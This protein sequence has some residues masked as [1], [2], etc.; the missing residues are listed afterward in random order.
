MGKL[1]ERDSTGRTVNLTGVR[2]SFGDSL[3]TAS[4]PKKNKD[5]SARPTHGVNLIIEKD[6][7]HFQSNYDAIITALSNAAVE[8]K[9]P[10]EWWRSLFEDDPKQLCLRKGSRFKTAE[11]EVYKGYDG[12]LVLVL[13]GPRGG[14]KRPEIRDRYKKIIFSE[15]RNV[16][17]PSMINE[18]AYNGSYADAIVS[19]YGTDNGGSDRLTGSCEALRSWQEGERLGGGGIYVEDDDFDDFEGEDSFDDGP[20]TGGT[21]ASAEP[22]KSTT[23][24]LDF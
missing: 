20:S 8:F 9:K 6:S 17:D 4:L 24:L 10:A 5:P 23:N 18:V 22:K 1:V 12:N 3:Q 19:F 13:K 7:Q 14:Q 15:P 11:G 16:L 21:T 2:I